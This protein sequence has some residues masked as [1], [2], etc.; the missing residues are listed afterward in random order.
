M[1]R[2]QVELQ[3]G[4]ILQDVIVGAFK[5]NGSGFE[6]WCR[7]NGINPSN[8]RQATFGQSR[9]P[10][11]KALLE[12]MIDAAGRD[13]VVAAYTNRIVALAEQ[14]KRGAA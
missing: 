6:T 5:A 2:K 11:G 8:A 12:R 1:S 14:L 3:P 13:F 10:A 7:D 4:A 9:G